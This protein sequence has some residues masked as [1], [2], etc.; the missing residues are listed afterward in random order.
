MDDMDDDFNEREDI[1]DN[2]SAFKQDL[3][4]RTAKTTKQE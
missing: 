1:I 2:E 3:V 4:P